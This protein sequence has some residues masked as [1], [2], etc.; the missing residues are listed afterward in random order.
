MHGG[1]LNENE[2]ITRDKKRYCLVDLLGW[3]HYFL[4]SSA[5]EFAL[6]D[7]RLGTLVF[8]V[9]VFAFSGEYLPFS[10]GE[11]MKEKKEKH[12]SGVYFPPLDCRSF[13]RDPLERMR[14]KTRTRTRI[15]NKNKW[16]YLYI[17]YTYYFQTLCGTKGR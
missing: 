9:V 17:V 2:I 14:A 16:G 7:G 13:R 8:M 10:R 1:E 15:S 5:F 6:L 3:K 4:F 11:E 12:I